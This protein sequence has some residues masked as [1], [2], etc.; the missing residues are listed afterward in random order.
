MSTCS[1]LDS[2]AA[3][4]LACCTAGAFAERKRL[5]IEHAQHATEKGALVKFADKICNL[6]DIAASP[7]MSWS[8]ERQR[9][10]FA[11]AKEVVDGLPPVSA[12]LRTL[13]D[14]A[15]AAKP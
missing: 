12:A 7:P 4:G 11:W 9:E 10:Y 8:K 1:R 5:Q 6:R 2:A 14:A 15:Y 3:W 13:F